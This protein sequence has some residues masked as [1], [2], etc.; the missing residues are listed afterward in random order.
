VTPHPSIRTV[1][2]DLKTSLLLVIAVWLV[3]FL[4]LQFI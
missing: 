1:M 4:A 3:T 2:N